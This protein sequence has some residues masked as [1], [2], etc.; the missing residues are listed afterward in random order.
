M[1]L[2]ELRVVDEV[3]GN[4]VG[5]QRIGGHEVFGVKIREKCPPFYL[6]ARYGQ[7]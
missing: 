6:T 7:R 2:E 3:L 4:G 1:L 5:V